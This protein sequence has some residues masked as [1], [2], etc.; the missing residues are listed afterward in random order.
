MHQSPVFKNRSPSDSYAN[1]NRDLHTAAKRFHAAH[2]DITALMY[3]SWKIFDNVFQYPE[4]YGFEA[5]DVQRSRGAIWMDHLHPTSKM[6]GVVADDLEDFLQQFPA[7]LPVT[8][9][10]V[11]DPEFAIGCVDMESR[12]R[13]KSMG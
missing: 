6:H 11:E 5:R 3:S 9:L 7:S 12:V 8:D 10:A 4:R 1:W 13:S 2:P